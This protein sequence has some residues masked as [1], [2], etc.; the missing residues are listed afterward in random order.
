MPRLFLAVPIAEKTKAKIGRKV[1]ELKS[2]LADWNVRWVAP[3]NLHIT[4]VF[5]DWVKE[6]Q[7]EILKTE[8]A[9]AVSELPDFKITTGRI[10]VEGRTILLEIENGREELH[11][12]SEEL[13]RK[14]TIKG[15][16]EE[17]RGF[18]SHLTLGRIKK[19]GRK[20][21][22][23]ITQTSRWRTDQ[24]ILYESR[25]SPKGPTYVPQLIFPLKG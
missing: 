25:L 24:I 22:P 16:L 5:F 9:S 20:N 14:L 8:I 21:L 7:I 10:S 3:E 23:K 1:D 11:R 2:N 18:H 13:I 17:E 4:L 6:E 12:I 19:R 15:P